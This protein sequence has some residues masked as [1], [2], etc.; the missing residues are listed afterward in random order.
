[1]IIADQSF[2]GTVSTEVSVEQVRLY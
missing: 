2:S 1:V